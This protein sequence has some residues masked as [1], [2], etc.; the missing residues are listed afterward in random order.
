MPILMILV[1]A[2]HVHPLGMQA[3]TIQVVAHLVHYFQLRNTCIH[4]YTE[5]HFKTV[6]G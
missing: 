5:I 1:V 2:L 6:K 4:T 3:P